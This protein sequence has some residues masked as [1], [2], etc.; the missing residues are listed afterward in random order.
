[1]NTTGFGK[2]GWTPEGLGKLAGKTYLITGANTGAGFAAARIL[3][4]KGAAVVMLNRSRQK[5]EW[6]M[7]DLRKELG[8]NARVSFIRM[9]LADLSSVREAVAEVLRTVPRID[10]LICNAAVAQV[11]K[12]SFTVDGFESQLGINHYGHFLL[13]NLLFARVEE[14]RGRIVVVSS[15][16]YKMGLKTIQFDDMNFDANYHPNT[17]YCHSKLA[18]MMFAYELQRRIAEAN[19]KVRCTFAT[20][21]LPI[22]PSST[23]ILP[24][25][26]ASPFP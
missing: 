24:C 15:E 3:L 22:P 26:L 8:A 16:G 5:S 4:R 21:E 23:K 10:A 20:P 1:M 13:T 18:Q 17:T 7:A 9:D 25:S 14:S 19:R 6:A 12:Q 11:A 2:E